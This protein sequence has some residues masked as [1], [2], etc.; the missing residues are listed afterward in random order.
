V[1]VRAASLAGGSRAAASARGRAGRPVRGHVRHAA[2]GCGADATLFD[3]LG[4]EPTLDDVLAGAWE[5]LAAHSVVACPVCGDDMAPQYG[6]HAA[7]VGGRCQGC[8]TTL[9]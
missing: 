7:P 4:G 2:R 8:G 1:T 3:G 6:Q 9:S 5:G